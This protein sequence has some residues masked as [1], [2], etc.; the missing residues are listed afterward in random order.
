VGLARGLTVLVVVLAGLWLLLAGA[1]WVFQRQI[2]YLPDRATPTAPADVEE[3]AL[4]TDDGL[5]L[6]AWFIAPPEPHAAILVTP[7]NAGSRALRLPLAEGL[8]ARGHAV[9]L[10]DYRGYGGNP[11]RPDEGGLL[12]DALAAREYLEGRD[13]LEGLPLIHLGESIGTGVAAALTRERPPDALVLRSPFP[14]LAEVG[15]GHYPFLPVRT[16]LR[17]RF[18]VVDDLT[19]WDGPTLVIAGDADR[20]VPPALSQQVAEA[21]DA[22]TVSLPGVD[23][24]DRAL[25][26]GTDYLDA[27][28]A[29]IRALD[30]DD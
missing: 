19:D 16:L 22:Q 8:A 13:D 3:V 12:T 9:L 11:G 5:T 24:N 15:A 21:V 26:D 17:E 27:V 25:L 1:A 20:I 6:T 29:F 14:S 23:H 18:P 4:S 7:G 10:L 2:V 28:D 30:E